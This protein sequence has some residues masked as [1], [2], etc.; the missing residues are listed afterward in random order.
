[1]TTSRAVAVLMLVVAT[2]AGCAATPPG[3]AGPDVDTRGQPA[4]PV[5]VARLDGCGVLRQT[6]PRDQPAGA[7]RLPD[8]SLP[9]LTSGPAVN[10]ARV[11]GR[12][13]VINLWATWCL[14]CRQEMPALQSASEKYP[15]V[16][17]LGI[18]TKDRNDWAQ[19]FL[20][21]VD[22]R[23]PQAVDADGRLLAALRSPGLPVTV[24][25]DRDGR[26]VGR[27]TGKIS[28]ARL[29]QLIAAAQR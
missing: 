18:D 12:A 19:E 3:P 6:A 24:V 23:Y 14:P 28:E 15:D 10:P 9:C 29:K 26:I 4:L 17:F 16:Q 2:L 27:Q 13:T 25:V 5:V 1:M 20:P 8:L 7:D 21:L 22:V 11:G